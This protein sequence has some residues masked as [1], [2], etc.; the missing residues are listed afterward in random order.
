MISKTKNWNQVLFSA[1]LT[2]TDEWSRKQ[3]N[4]TTDGWSTLISQTTFLG[5]LWFLKYTETGNVLETIRRFRKR[6]PNQ[7]RPCRQTIMDNYDKYVQYGLSLNS[8]KSAIVDV[9][10]SKLPLKS[11]C[12]QNITSFCIYTF[13]PFPHPFTY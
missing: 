7:R 3:K 1:F 10:V 2:G 6:F 13:K 12:F 4:C 5:Y 11:D 9:P 8:R